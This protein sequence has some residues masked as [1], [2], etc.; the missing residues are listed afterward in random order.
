[1]KEFRKFEEVK[2]KENVDRRE[3]GEREKRKININEWSASCPVS[4]LPNF[5]FV[6]I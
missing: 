3:E 2:E 6:S 5:V 4:Y 1:M